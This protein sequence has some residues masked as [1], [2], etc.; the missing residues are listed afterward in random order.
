MIKK[1][2]ILYIHHG[3]GIGGAPLSL[4]YLIKEID[5][6]KYTPK[7]LFIAN[8]D[9]VELY[10]NN[11]IDYSI[12]KPWRILNNYRIFNHNTADWIKW[13]E[14]HRIIFSV[15]A[16][17]YS[18]FFYNKKYL[19]KE[20]P[21]I[22]HLN[23][24]TL[25]SWTISS[26]FLNIPVVFHIR[27]RIVNG[28]F[29][30]R[31][32]IIKYIVN[33]YVN[34]V[35]AISQDN[36]R[37]LGLPDKTK[38]VY[39]FVDFNTFNKSIK[40]AEININVK[41]KKIVIYT[42]G[43]IKI[44]GFNILVDALNYLSPNIIVLFAGYYNYRNTF[45]MKIINLLT[46]KKKYLDKLYNSSNAYVIG[47]QKNIAEWIALSD[48]LIFPAIVPHFARPVIEAGAIGKPV[49]A[50]N[51]E[52]IEEL[53]INNFNGLLVK[54]NDSKDLAEKINYI[55]ANENIAEKLGENGY[56]RSLK[57]FNA[58]INAIETIS[59]YDEIL[60]SK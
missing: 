56:E 27:E 5:R 4:L 22:V 47:V 18:V 55:C 21:D 34:K 54:P 7:V 10:K 8:S 24:S 3:S 13:W 16:F 2:K 40:P 37:F 26:A 46:K 49:I 51:L 19:K 9:V 41:N 44:K 45:K 29:G 39:N 52:G 42:G 28:Y 43:R 50:T 58:E 48:L 1:K 15:L 11:G 33:K 31:K 36:A 14:I 12:C 6:N 17:I 57:L 30:I 53:V 59:V 32:I 23:S 25:L 35:I 20:Q 60:L 38:V